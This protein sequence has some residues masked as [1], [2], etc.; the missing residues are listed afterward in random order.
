[1]YMQMCNAMRK[2][3]IEQEAVAG[4]ILLVFVTL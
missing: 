2:M 3:Q 1:M 4:H